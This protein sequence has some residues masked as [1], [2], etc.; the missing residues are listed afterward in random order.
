[1]RVA[2]L[3]Q[4]ELALEQPMLDLNLERQR[5][6]GW[7][8]VPLPEPRLRRPKE[9]QV[10][11]AAARP[12]TKAQF[13]PGWILRAVLT[14]N[15]RGAEPEQVA[16]QHLEPVNPFAKAMT[17]AQLLAGRWP[18]APV[19]KLGKPRSMKTKVSAQLEQAVRPQVAPD[20]LPLKKAPFG[21]TSRTVSRVAREAL[22]TTA[23][24]GPQASPV[25][26]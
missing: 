24:L 9:V 1:V 22:G 16:G 8:L 5:A 11:Q 17:A 12:G 23:Q 21:T 4:A 15:L 19:V 13:E 2:P 25:P 14:T 3:H 7:P 26:R 20:G 18:P 6:P 10:A